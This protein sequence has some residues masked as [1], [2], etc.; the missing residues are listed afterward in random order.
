ML[1]Q[2]YQNLSGGHHW[3]PLLLN[4]SKPPHKRKPAFTIS[5]LNRKLC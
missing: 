2:N 1:E 5:S 4:F 3:G